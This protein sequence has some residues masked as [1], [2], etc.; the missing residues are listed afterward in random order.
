MRRLFRLLAPAIAAMLALA[1]PA[2]VGEVAVSA[3]LAV[4]L[5]ALTLRDGHRAGAASLPSRIPD[6]ATT[7]GRAQT[8]GC[9]R[10]PQARGERE[11]IARWAQYRPADCRAEQPYV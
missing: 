1:P 2:L 5:F 9:S 4:P 7:R 11:V 8:D 10:P 6:G 3:A